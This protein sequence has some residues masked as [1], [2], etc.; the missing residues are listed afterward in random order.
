MEDNQKQFK[1]SV[2]K[3]FFTTEGRLKSIPVQLKKKLVVLEHL[4]L[5]LDNGRKYS[6][7]EMNEIIKDYHEDFATIRR[8][9]IM[10]QFMYRDNQ[11]YE[12]NPEEMWTKWDALS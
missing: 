4:I 7:K 6:E 9:F 11:I 10:H 3:N 1:E 12:V 2:I 5:K 8:E